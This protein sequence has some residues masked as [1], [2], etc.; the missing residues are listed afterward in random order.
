LTTTKTINPRSAQWLTAAIFGKS[1]DVFSPDVANPLENT[2]KT[3]TPR[4]ANILSL[5]FGLYDNSGYG[6]TLQQVGD[7]VGVSAERIR[8][9]EAK[10]FRRLRHPSRSRELRK[11]IIQNPGV[12]NE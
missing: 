6:R 1:P 2:L 7:I 5:R 10:A 11:Y 12:V 3:L 9:I 4:E 8:Q